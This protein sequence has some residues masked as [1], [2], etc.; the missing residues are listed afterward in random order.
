MDDKGQS[1]DHSTLVQQEL[2]NLGDKINDHQSFPDGGLP[3][4]LVVLG[5]FFGLFVSFGWTN[6][7]VYLIIL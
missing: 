6:C 1:Y 2:H 5:A 3:A 4:W 7:T